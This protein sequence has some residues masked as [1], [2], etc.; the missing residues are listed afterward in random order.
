MQRLRRVMEHDPDMETF[1]HAACLTF[2]AG[3]ISG[4]C[5]PDD[6][7]PWVMHAHKVMAILDV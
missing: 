3:L 6:G 2:A 4:E 1:V 5:K 7:L